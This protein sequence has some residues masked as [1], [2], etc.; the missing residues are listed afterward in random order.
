MEFIMFVKTFFSA[1]QN[2]T[3]WFIWPR[4][5]FLGW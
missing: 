4:K 5:A 3:R 1:P 2:Y